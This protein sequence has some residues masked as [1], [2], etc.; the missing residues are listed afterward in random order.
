MTKTKTDKAEK[1]FVKK[2]EEA[3][4]KKTDEAKN[5]AAADNAVIKTKLKPWSLRR[6]IPFA[7]HTSAGATRTKHHPHHA[8][9][10][11]A[12]A[13]QKDPL[14][15]HKRSRAPRR[16][17]WSPLQTRTAEE[18]NNARS[19]EAFDKEMKGLID[20]HPGFAFNEKTPRS[21]WARDKNFPVQAHGRLYNPSPTESQK[22]TE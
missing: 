7:S 4:K 5:N 8:S 19:F 15:P 21:I 16:E 1:N 2:A 22:A 3:D 11:S 10:M 17:T 18:Y 6:N 9:R 14:P 20:E 12:G 13:S